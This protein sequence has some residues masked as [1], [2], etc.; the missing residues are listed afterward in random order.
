MDNA[1]ASSNAM[2]ANHNGMNHGGMNHS[3]EPKKGSFVNPM[4]HVNDPVQKLIDTTQ[5]THVAVRNGAWSN[6]KTWKN[7]RVPGDNAK[8]MIN[9]GVNV[10]YDQV[11]DARIQIVSVEG[12][13]KFAT[14]KDTQLKVETILNASSGRVDVGSTGNAVRADKQARIIFTSDRAID[15]KW[16]PTQLSKGFVSHGVVN[17][18]GADKTDSVTLVGDVKKGASV[19]RFKEPLTGWKVGDRIVLGG[20]KYSS[21]GNNGDNS[22]FQDEVLKITSING[23]EVRFE[24]ED[25]KSGNRN[26]LRFD[27]TRSN[28]AGSADKLSLYAANMSRNVSFETENGK[29]V[30]I[31]RRAHV[32]LMHNPNVNVVNAGFYELGRSDKSKLVDDPGKNIDGS[33]G[34]GTN[35]RG[36]YSLHLH[37]TGADD[38]NG[39]AAIL[40]GNAV[41]GSPGWGI[42][43]HDSHAGL[44]D[45][46][47]FDVVGAGI[48]A[49]SG[50]EIG[51]WTNNLT[52][53]TTGSGNIVDFNQQAVAREKRY[54]FGIQGTGFWIQGPGLIKNTNNKAISSNGAG[55]TVFG[56][57][58]NQKYLR[59]ATTLEIKNL[60][61]ELRK[62]FPASQK[63]VDIRDLPMG[64]IT[65]LE[66]YNASLGLRIW[67]HNTNFDGELAFNTKDPET[68]HQ[69]RSLVKDAKLWSNRFRGVS[70]QYSTNVDVKDSIILGNEDGKLRAFNAG[71][72][73]NRE[74]YGSVFDNLTVAGFELGADI[75]PPNSDKEFI[76]A[77]ISNSTFSN[78]TLNLGEAGIRSPQGGFTDFPAYLKVKSNKFADVAGNQ[79]PTASFDAKAIGGLAFELD[80][81]DSFDKDPL[82]GGNP[83]QSQLQSKGVAAY[84]W[85]L[86]GNGSIDRFGREL[87]H[88]F[89]KAGKQNVSLTVW[90]SQGKTTT[91]KQTLDVRPAPFQNAFVN[92]N[93]NNSKTL[94]AGFDNSQWA[95]NGWFA[96]KGVKIAN[97]I[98]KIS[99]AGDRSNYMGQVVTNNK[100]HKGAQTLSFDLRNIDANKSQFDA[101]EVTVTFWGVNGQFE[102]K[103]NETTG[104]Y[105]VGT[106]PMQR[107][108]LSTQTFNKQNGG[109]GDW[110]KISKNVD[111]GNGY[112]YLLFQVNAKKINAPQDFVAIDNVSLT[113]T[114]NSGKNPTKP[115]QPVNPTQPVQ[116]VNP[117]QP[118]Q[119][120]QPTNPTKP[121]QPVSPVTPKPPTNG[122]TFP[123]VLDPVA[124]IKFDEGN[125]TLAADSSNNGRKNNGR[126]QNGAQWIDGKFG[127]AAGF[128]GKGSRVA[129]NNSRDINLRTS[130]ERTVSMWF[131]T[132]DASADKKQVIFE[133]GGRSRGLNMYVEDDSLIFGGWSQSGGWGKGSWIETNKIESGKWHHVA[134]V[135]DGDRKLAPNVL[136]AYLDGQKL[137]V[138]QG[139]QLMQHNDRI[140]I[141]NTNGS[142]LFADGTVGKQ[143]Q[144]GL[145]GGVDQLQIFNSALSAN[146]VQQLSNGAIL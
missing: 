8:V 108:L 94:I 118:T 16:D 5:H 61:A 57:S 97:G 139:T 98:G 109:L 48:A 75:A 96:S 137:G 130:P 60:P 46:V 50:N 87:T 116:P 144:A 69:G 101:N 42:V 17:V 81:G 85:D 58:L 76:S 99:K 53:K 25:I 111:L 32:M 49:E 125:K 59:D 127:Q 134:L 28:I 122:P 62:L 51:W 2:M 4:S 70:V 27:H 13:L 143:N 34:N 23:K 105:Q 40:R 31:N 43:Q 84:G 54:D 133:E 107:A 65:G 120:T 56:S 132:D 129:I 146:Q 74:S 89:N 63:E 80:A 33:N 6:P 37:R 95:D 45:N 29:N 9:K 112:D 121:T 131:K 86:D 12:T 55:M 47:V 82:R 124:T 67:A 1:S 136:T 15:T 14:G 7:G 78:N 79:A 93:F 92:A 39:K 64:T 135:L 138:K 77:T 140:G 126:L 10:T 52:I 26:V 73:V 18:Q 24:N 20:T 38:P 83:N 22:K 123:S 41:I 91:T 119:P 115:I 113:R 117:T 71:I 35:P 66:S 142:T 141:G 19:L 21:R 102:N 30:P 128:N 103:S 90:D 44:E 106:L 36:R 68:A 110:K 145:L 114:A 104:P 100:V 11:S 88:V 72:L 3:T